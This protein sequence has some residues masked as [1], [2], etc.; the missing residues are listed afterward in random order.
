MKYCRA[1]LLLEDI[2]LSIWA[3][4]LPG[5]AIKPTVRFRQ[6]VLT[7]RTSFL[8]RLTSLFAYDRHLV[9]DK[10][11]KQV[12]LRIRRYWRI[13]QDQQFPFDAVRFIQYKFGRLPT[14]FGYV[15]HG[16]AV[17]NSVS[18]FTVALAMKD[19]TDPVFLFRFI[20]EGSGM[21]GVDG[22]LGGDTLLDLEGKQEDLSRD[23]VGLLS[24]CLGVPV[25]TDL[26]QEVVD[27]MK[28]TLHPCPV[29]KRRI[30]R[31]APRCVYCGKKF[32]ARRAG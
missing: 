25:A 23:F 27:A 22:M 8:L 5:L 31:T 20:G 12:R 2:S 28:S 18:W 7:A 10:S 19:R 26:Q 24:R 1:G 4:S 6:G 13:H 16:A 14:R 29:C 15:I 17:T 3:L 21:T 11:R 30:S 32:A 9:V